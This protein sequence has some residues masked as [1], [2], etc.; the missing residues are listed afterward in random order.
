MSRERNPP[1]DNKGTNPSVLI[2]HYPRID[3]KQ[4]LDRPGIKQV[5]RGMGSESELA[6][7]GCA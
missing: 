2:S 1:V 3:N 7:Y 5:K 6:Q 4:Q